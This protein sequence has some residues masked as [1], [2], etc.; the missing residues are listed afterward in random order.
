MNLKTN[1]LPPKKMADFLV[2]VHHYTYKIETK[3]LSI[4]PDSPAYQAGLLF[5]R[6]H[7]RTSSRHVHQKTNSQQSKF[8]PLIPSASEKKKV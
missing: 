4:T 5:F 6:Y 1:L 8:S 3:N 2:H 7:N